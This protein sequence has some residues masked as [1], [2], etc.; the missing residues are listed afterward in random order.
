MQA[1]PRSASRWGSLTRDLSRSSPNPF[2]CASCLSQGAYKPPQRQQLQQRTFTPSTSL[3]TDGPTTTSSSSLLPPPPPPTGHARL[4]SRRLLSLSGIDAPHFLQ[5]L[6]TTSIEGGESLKNGRSSQS[7]SSPQQQ[8]WH[9]CGFLNALGRVLHD[10]FIYPVPSEAGGGEPHFLIE[11]DAAQA[12][13]LLRHLKRYKLRSKIAL[14]AVD[15]EEMSVWQVWDDS[16]STS[17]S[18]LT[19]TSI[20]H[21]NNNN[22]III[23]DLRAPGMGY[24]VLS[25]GTDD[26]DVNTLSSSQE[27]TQK[28]GEENIRV[29]EQAYRIRR[30]LHGVPEGATEIPPAHALPQESNMDLMGGI[31][32]RKGCYVGQEL[33]IRTRHRGVVRKRVLPCVLYSGDDSTPPPDVLRYDPSSTPP[34]ESGVAGLTISRHNGKKKGRSTGTFLSGIGNIGLALCRV[35]FM[36]DLVVPNDTPG[37]SLDYDPRDEFVLLPR[38]EDADADADAGPGTGT[39][40]V[41]AFVPEWLRTRL[42]EDVKVKH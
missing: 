10:V 4:T 31:D 14:R 19:S 41:K 23:P 17:T 18:T 20:L 11:V 21:T 26:L 37:A 28:R 25:R 12:T 1:L 35:Q 40:K 33:T 6:T 42:A 15:E 27:Q 39:V 30:Y 5:G 7:Q 34:L 13:A 8:Y 3:R 2:I 16:T 9:Y 22:T 32:F 38:P 29:D 36:T 24:R